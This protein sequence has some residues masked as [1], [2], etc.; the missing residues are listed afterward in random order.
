MSTHSRHS[1][2]SSRHRQSKPGHVGPSFAESL[3]APHESAGHTSSVLS[4]NDAS[5]DLTAALSAFEQNH[6]TR[7][8]QIE[9]RLAAAERALSDLGGQIKEMR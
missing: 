5:A 7:L 1:A 8:A 9:E 2:D 4:N 6:S 3:P